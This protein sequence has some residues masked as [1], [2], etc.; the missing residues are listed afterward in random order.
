M[1]NY[2]ILRPLCSAIALVTD[3]YN[4]YGEGKLGPLNAY[5]YLAMVINCSQVGPACVRARV[6]CL[7]LTRGAGAGGSSRRVGFWG[8]RWRHQGR[9]LPSL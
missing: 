1:V 7:T 6:C 2:V 9:V 8:L 3:H 5:P 4:V